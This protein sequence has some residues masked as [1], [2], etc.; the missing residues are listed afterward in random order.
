ML[1]GTNIKKAFS[2]LG[3]DKTD[4]EKAIKNAYREKLTLTNPEDDPE[5]FKALRSAYDTA[6]RYA[7][8]AKKPQS[9][10]DEQTGAEATPVD[11]WIEKVADTYRFLSKRTDI[12]CWKDLFEDEIFDSLEDE[13]E[14][15]KK[16]LIFL[17][18]HYRLPV[19]IWRFLDGKL[20]LV[21]NENEL[22]HSFAP[23]FVEYVLQSI[24]GNSTIAFE[25][26]EGD[27]DADIDSFIRYYYSA[28]NFY[29]EHDY[30]QALK[31]IDSAEALNIY[32]PE[33]EVI[34]ILIEKTD[35]PEEALSMVTELY[36]KYPD[37]IMLQFQFS[38][39]LWKNGRHEE[40]ANVYG[41]ILE[42]NPSH[43][44][45][46]K[47]LAEHCF[48]N[49]NY[50]NARKYAEKA[51]D[52]YPED[53]NLGSMLNTVNRILAKK[54]NNEWVNN[55]NWRSGIEL[56]KCLHRSGNIIIAASIGKKLKDLV[57][58]DMLTEYYCIMAN[59]YAESGDFFEGYD[60]A[61]KW[62]SRLNQEIVSKDGNEKKDCEDKIHKAYR[63]I[64]TCLKF[65]SYADASYGEKAVT[66][67]NDIKDNI[68][69]DVNLLL[70]IADVMMS[71]DR[72]DIT[73]EIG[74]DLYFCY[75]SPW[76]AFLALCGSLWNRQYREAYRMAKICLDEM[77]GLDA[78]YNKTAILYFDTDNYDKLYELKQKALENNVEA[79]ALDAYVNLAKSGK[80][81]IQRSELNATLRGDFWNE[82][83]NKLVDGDTTINRDEA[84]NGVIDLFNHCPDGVA[85]YLDIADIYVII[86]DIDRALRLLNY[87][88]RFI[89]TKS[90]W[91]YALLSKCYVMLGDY[92]KCVYYGKIAILSKADEKRTLEDYSRVARGYMCMGDN[93][94]AEKWFLK[95]IENSEKQGNKDIPSV[96]PRAYIRMNER[97]KFIN[98]LNELTRSEYTDDEGN[99]TLEGYKFI[100][101]LLIDIGDNGLVKKNLED[102]KAALDKLP[103]DAENYTEGLYD[104]YESL[105]YYY[106]LTGD[107]GSTQEAYEKALEVTPYDVT[108]DN[109]EASALESILFAAIL[110]DDRETW[111]KYSEIFRTYVDVR[112]HGR[113]FAEH[114]CPRQWAY[115]VWIANF[116]NYSLA[117]A[118][119]KLDDARNNYICKACLSPFCIELEALTCMAY[120]HKGD[121]EKT[122]EELDKVFSKIPN[123][124]M[125][126]PIQVRLNAIL[127]E[128]KNR[129]P[130]QQ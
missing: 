32:H 36:D 43:Y 21:K 34:R 68:Q 105:G 59:I 73:T 101:N 106:L 57:E 4:D 65:L 120:L 47:R 121:Y 44:I 87:V 81:P 41:K 61:F 14:A 39:L 17:M 16:L 130:E 66:L 12:S 125:F 13:N 123:D 22:R 33:L 18:E 31:D 55:R 119:E 42:K 99:I 100:N 128:T 92:D 80:Q 113:N 51:Y 53:E 111:N 6:L 116:Y 25:D 35:E 112:E 89:K 30:E 46:N 78:V 74:I 95:Y 54:Y 72:H 79:I 56:C 15:R 63:L 9:S 62:L 107:Y 97:E 98:C 82:V 26:F 50:E 60:Y 93:E 28:W 19:K 58:A 37:N 69:N 29:S 117:E 48:K 67:Y 75:N 2:I 52:V 38:E 102:F 91:L 23:N 108:G 27:D 24:R 114:D 122:Q 109:P 104:Y 76:G 110:Y 83:R 118:F 70:S 1:T 71:F 10:D 103:E 20:E 7:D 84:V 115:T 45:S 88:I 3:I 126:V 94:E 49:E 5:G 8:E 77:P 86:L 85:S 96:L 127:Q 40:A 11:F 124:S 90:W 129:T 64:F